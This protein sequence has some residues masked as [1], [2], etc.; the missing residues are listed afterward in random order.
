MRSA[1]EVTS[2]VTRTFAQQFILPWVELLD[3]QTDAGCESTD[4]L[5]LIAEITNTS[6]C[7]K[8]WN[9]D[10]KNIGPN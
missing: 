4:R 9:C 3:V 8:R 10:Q 5:L 6:D 7:K 1:R 2:S